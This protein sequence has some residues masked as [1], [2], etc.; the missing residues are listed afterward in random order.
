MYEKTLKFKETVVGTGD[1]TCEKGGTSAAN[2]SFQLDF[3]AFKVLPQIVTAFVND[4]KTFI[5]LLNKH[6]NL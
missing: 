5:I 1:D 6:Y 2:N 3:V 4:S